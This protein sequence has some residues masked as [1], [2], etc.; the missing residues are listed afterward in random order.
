MKYLILFLIIAFAI[1]WAYGIY[2]ATTSKFNSKSLK[3][4]WI[5]VILFIPISVFIYFYI[6]DKKAPQLRGF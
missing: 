3:Y 4:I 2:N 1:F 6:Y 5:A